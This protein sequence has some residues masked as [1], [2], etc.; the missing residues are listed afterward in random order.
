MGDF[1]DFF[2]KSRNN[3]YGCFIFHVSCERKR[4]V[5]WREESVPMHV[6][7]MDYS[8]ISCHVFV[9]YNM[10]TVDSQ[11]VNNAQRFYKVLQFE[12]CRT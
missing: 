4:P 3:L 11:T 10:Y 8:A 7:L 1:A 6:N 5:I 2:D 9:T 12:I